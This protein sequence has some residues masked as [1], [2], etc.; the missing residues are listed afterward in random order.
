MDVKIYHSQVYDSV[1]NTIYNKHVFINSMNG[2]VLESILSKY[3]TN[4]IG[5]IHIVSY[6][7]QHLM[8][9]IYY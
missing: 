1:E 2:N 9:N 8:N 3:V 6:Q 7:S 5:P 4:F